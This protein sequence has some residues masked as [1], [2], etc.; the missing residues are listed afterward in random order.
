M[1][2]LKVAEPGQGVESVVFCYFHPSRRVS[3]SDFGFSQPLAKYLVLLQHYADLKQKQKPLQDTISELRATLENREQKITSTEK[4]LEA[5]KFRS[6]TLVQEWNAKKGEMLNLKAAHQKEIENFK[7]ELASEHHLR[8]QA[9][10]L[11]KDI[12]R[13]MTH[14]FIVP[15]LID[16]FIIFSQGPNGVP[17]DS[18]VSPTDT[19]GTM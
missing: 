3:L 17:E 15:G 13:E 6:K 4:A 11:E 2:R 9:E 10:K 12:R 8:L 16:A 19:A 14:P 5:E 1:K 7:Q 18:S